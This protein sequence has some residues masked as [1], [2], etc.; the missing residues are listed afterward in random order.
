MPSKRFDVLTDAHNAI[1][2]KQKL[3]QEALGREKEALAQQ[4]E[5]QQRELKERNAHSYPTLEEAHANVGRR[6]QAEAQLVDNARTVTGQTNAK[7]SSLNPMQLDR[8]LA[9]V[10]PAPQTRPVPSRTD[11]QLTPGGT[12]F[13]NK[14]GA[15]QPQ[16]HQEP[17]PRTALSRIQDANETGKN[18]GIE[19]NDARQT[20]AGREASREMTD[21]RQGNRF[22][23]T[24]TE[25]MRERLERSAITTG[26]GGITD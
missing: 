5:A 23:V 6:D 3:Q 4:K 12:M 1:E 2:V 10:V 25:K 17:I 8:R 26:R 14:P 15:Q 19:T 24:I 21:A 7:A 22:K 18:T 13:T 9:D 16:Q 11:V 20:R